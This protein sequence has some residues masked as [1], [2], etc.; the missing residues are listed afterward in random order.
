[1]EL[2]IWQ[3]DA[4]AEKLFE[5]N[6]AA[7]IP[8]SDWLPDE[9][10]QAI[11]AENNLSETAFFVPLTPGDYARC[12]LRWFTPQVEVPLCGHATL[13]SGHVILMHLAPALDAVSFSTQS[14]DLVVARGS[15]GILE[16]ALPA[17]QAVPHPEAED[18]AEAI[19][20]ALDLAPR[21]VLKANYAIA[22]FATVDEILEAEADSTLADALEEFGED[23]IIITAAGGDTGFDFVSR[24]F[25]PG[26]GV[27]EDPVTGS[28]HA[29]LA[30]FWARRLGKL[31]LRARQLSA[32]GGT[33]DCEVQ[34]ERVLIRGRVTP[35]LE[36]VIRI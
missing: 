13:A 20:E 26:K 32:R 31:R 7:V 16:M 6:P 5:G 8:L 19:E 14:G 29:A 35:Y 3:V 22:L 36:G 10:M 21:E 4:F 17:Y 15:G 11:A 9:Q 2:R 30:P 18:L 34:G 1:M 25:V 33:L 23:G 12:Q 24:F 28:A 27:P